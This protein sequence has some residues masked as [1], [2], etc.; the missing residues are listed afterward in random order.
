MFT[1]LLLEREQAGEGQRESDRENPKQALHCQ[2]RVQRGAQTHEPW[3]HDMS[4][5]QQTLNQLSHP[6]A[7]EFSHFNLLLYQFASSA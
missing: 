6:G 4:Q 7:P 1:Y 5:N 2:H 3:D